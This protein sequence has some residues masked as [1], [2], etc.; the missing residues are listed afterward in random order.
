[1]DDPQPRITC[2]WLSTPPSSRVLRVETGGGFV[3]SDVSL[4][5]VPRFS[6]YGDGRV[7]VTGPQIEIYP[8]PALPNLQSRTVDEAGAQAIRLAARE[9]GLE[10]ADRRYEGNKRVA[11][12]GTTTFTVAA[13]GEVHTTSV[14]A[15]F[16]SEES[17]GVSEE[18]REAR[19]KLTAF[20]QDLGDLKRWLPEGSVGP[21][22][23]F[24][25][26]GLR[27]FV[28]PSFPESGEQL[29]E[30]E[31]VW[32]LVT[33]LSAFGQ[34]V[35]GQPEVRCGVA[36]GSNADFLRPL[37]TQANQLTPWRSGDRTY[38]LVFRPLLPDET[39]C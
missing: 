24:P 4:T 31:K 19:R 29:N 37:V 36:E 22:G 20:D 34:P 9:A 17:A 27:V 8:G 30:P 25:S 12:A 7:V 28:I 10:G 11:D 6:L 3:P 39:G 1:M 21:E 15:L 5:Q 2:A 35:D 14:Y 38:H 26:N 23:A 18:E 16:D 13:N 33:P 32:P